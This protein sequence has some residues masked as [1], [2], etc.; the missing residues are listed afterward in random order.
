M[1]IMKLYKHTQNIYP[2][3]I[4]NVEE[5]VEELLRKDCIINFDDYEKA[6]LSLSF[7]TFIPNLYNTM[8]FIP[9]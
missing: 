4:E 6:M 9:L 1:P 5:R 8:K 3:L 2:P 7:N